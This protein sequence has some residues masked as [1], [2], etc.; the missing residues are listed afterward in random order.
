MD[1]V[2]SYLLTD[3]CRRGDVIEVDNGVVSRTSLVVLN[4]FSLHVCLLLIDCI[5]KLYTQKQH[6][7][8]STEN[9]VDTFVLIIFKS[10]AVIL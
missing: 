8:N 2:T 10:K 4:R 6:T 7:S 9:V 1:D 5:V 3:E